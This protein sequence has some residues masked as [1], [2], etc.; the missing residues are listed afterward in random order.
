MRVPRGFADNQLSACSQALSLP[1]GPLISLSYMYSTMALGCSSRAHDASRRLQYSH[2]VSVLG[3][4]A[5][6]AVCRYQLCAYRQQ[7]V[8]CSARLHD[9]L[10]GCVGHKFF[11]IQ[12]S[13]LVSSSKKTTIS[14]L[15]G[16]WVAHAVPM[17]VSGGFEGHE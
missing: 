6:P 7:L 11:A 1:Y 2:V 17:I 8:C 13:L 10:G 3:R 16:S 4:S 15:T 5:C 9:G 12:L 14:I